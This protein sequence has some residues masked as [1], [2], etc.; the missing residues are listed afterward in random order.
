MKV[1]FHHSGQLTTPDAIDRDVG[2]D[3]IAAIREAL[4][5]WLPDAA[6]DWLRSTA[7]MYTNTPDEH[8]VIGSHPRHP[9]VIL[10]GGFSGH[11]FKF[12]SVVGEVLAGLAAHEAA[13]C[14]ISLFAPDRFA[15]EMGL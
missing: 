5:A 15:R 14:S 1:A 8:F 2:A 11:G 7:C 3:E 13:S 10:A 4:T 9:Q 6:G 12:C